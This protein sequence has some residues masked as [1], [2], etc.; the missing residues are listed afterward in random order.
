MAYKLHKSL[1]FPMDVGLNIYVFYVS[2]EGECGVF[3]SYLA[4][5]FLAEGLTCKQ[6]LYVSS[7]DC[8]AHQ[9]VSLRNSQ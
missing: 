6:C 2:E 3:S 9:L 1:F 4:K 8:D 5:F 7:L